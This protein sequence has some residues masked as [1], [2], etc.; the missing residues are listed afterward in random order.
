MKAKPSQ[1]NLKRSKRIEANLNKIISLRTNPMALTQELTRIEEDIEEDQLNSDRYTRI[2]PPIHSS[3]ALHA[4][5]ENYQDDCVTSK[6]PRTAITNDSQNK[7]E[8]SPI[9]TEQS[10]ESQ[11]QLQ[12]QQRTGKELWRLLQSLQVQGRSATTA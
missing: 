3:P 12:H 11:A 8:A 4:T 9:A 6:T 7:E 5:H 2:P 10:E 1:S